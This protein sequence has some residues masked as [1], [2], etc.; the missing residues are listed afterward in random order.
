M[1]GWRAGSRVPAVYLHLSGK[2]IDE[3][4]SIM[5]GV[6]R[7]K[8]TR[9]DFRPKQCLRCKERNNPTSKFCYRCGAVLD[10]ETAVQIDHARTRIDQL[11][12]KPTEDPKKLEKLLALLEE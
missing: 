8:D 3:A 11:L 7:V 5:N 6:T 1:L 2:D 4:Q 10:I 9:L 12:N